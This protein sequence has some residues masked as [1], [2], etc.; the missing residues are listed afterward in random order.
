[1]AQAIDPAQLELILKTMG[2]ENVKEVTKA[3][4][5][6]GKEAKATVAPLDQAK[7]ALEA[8]KDSSQLTTQELDVLAKQASKVQKTTLDAE[9][10][11]KKVTQALDDETIAIRNA[12][13]AAEKATGEGEGEE[14]KGGFKGMA[15]GAIK[16]E[17]AINSLMSGKGLGRLGSLLESVMGPLGV[18]GL[19][20]A[21][22]AIAME[23]EPA[24]RAISSFIDLWD[25]G[26]GPFKDAATAIERLGRA[27]GDERRERAYKRVEARIAPLEEKLETQGFLSAEETLQL[28]RLH[29]AAARFELEASEEAAA[30]DR[31][32]RQQ[33]AKKESADI[34]LQFDK[35]LRDQRTAA[36]K[37]SAAIDDQF[38][39]AQVDKR[40]Q[41][42]REVQE[43]LETAQNW[44]VELD[45]KALAA[46]SHAELKRQQAAR[47]AAQERKRIARESTP[48]A[49]EAAEEKELRNR[50][51]EEERAQNLFRGQMGA[52][53]F[54]PS[55]L[56]QIRG[57]VE[58]HLH[59]AAN[60]GWNLGQLVDW[61]MSQQAVAIE[62]GMRNSLFGTANRQHVTS[63]IFQGTR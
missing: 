22:G 51:M 57:R 27:Q 25:K 31:R 7:Q 20:L 26:I 46:E 38:D 41:H 35:Y 19:G 58:S 56:G 15:G 34:D 9:D 24:I 63:E 61:A 49:L 37:E 43:G 47:Q 40:K 29:E 1:M 4:E 32:K 14:A 39:R 11:L 62:Q 17:K 48:E 3:F 6:L 8:T 44:K 36:Q 30:Q 55:E 60:L 45:N 2:I 50:I 52:Q 21:F 16:A 13:E 18:P 10:A 33:V 53:M 23:A 59:E 12:R 28:R 54:A 42:A 5:D